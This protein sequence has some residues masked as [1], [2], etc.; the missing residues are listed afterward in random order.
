MDLVLPQRL[1]SGQVDRHDAGLVVRAQYLRLVRVDGERGDVPV[2]H[3]VN[4]ASSYPALRAI[5]SAP[6]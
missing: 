5:H 4:Y 3:A 6:G 2:I 1:A